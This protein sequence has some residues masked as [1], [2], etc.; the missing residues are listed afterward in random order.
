MLREKKSWIRSL[1]QQYLRHLNNRFVSFD[2][3]T[4]LVSYDDLNF[5]RYIKQLQSLFD[6]VLVLHFEDLRRNQDLFI[7][8]ICTFIGCK[9]PKYNH[10]AKNVSLKLDEDKIKRMIRFQKIL[11]KIKIPNTLIIL[12]KQT[13]YELNKK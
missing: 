11:K 3:F 12:W 6:S 9:F 2:E 10:E 7:N 8:K 4:S 13:V 5:D 1:Y